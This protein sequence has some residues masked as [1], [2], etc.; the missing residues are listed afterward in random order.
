MATDDFFRARLNTMIDLRHSL[1]VLA[2]RMP[3]AQI[4][5]SRAPAF[6][7][8]DRK[9]R[10]IEGADLFGPSVAVVGSGVSNQACPVCRSA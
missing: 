10:T 8:R 5:A 4:E 9:D 3:W 7:H 6:A 2:M 1:A